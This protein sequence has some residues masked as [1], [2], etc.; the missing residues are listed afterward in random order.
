MAP[1]ETSQER[2]NTPDLVEK[3]FATI[4]TLRYVSNYLAF[5]CRIDSKIMISRSE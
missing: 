4:N 3:G 5:L 1:R 2:T